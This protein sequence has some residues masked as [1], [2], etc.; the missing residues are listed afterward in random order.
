MSPMRLSGAARRSRRVAI[1]LSLFAIALPACKR[2]VTGREFG[3]GE[4]ENVRVDPPYVRAGVPM[5]IS[6]NLAGGVQRTVDYSIGGKTFECI[7]ERLAN[8]RLECLHAGVTRAEYMQGP[9]DVVVKTNNR[10]GNETSGSTNITI[11]FD[12]PEIS[13]LAVTPGIGSPGTMVR[14]DIIADEALSL[15][16]VVSR[17]G[18]VWETPIGL[19]STWETTHVVT[20]EDQ[21]SA[22][23]VIVRLVDL[24][25]NTSGDCGVDG[26]KIFS[27][28][29][30]APQVF[31]DKIEVLRD[32]PGLPATIS[33]QPGAFADDVGVTEV[34][35]TT[36]NESGA[37]HVVATLMPLSD[38]S[39]PLTAI[40]N[41]LTGRA[42]VQAID[43]AGQS[44]GPVLVKERWRLSVGMGQ[45]ADAAIR[46]ATR[47]T[48]APPRTPSLDNRTRELAVAIFNADTESAVVES[49]VGFKVAGTLPT[50]YRDTEFIATGY[51]KK[52]KAIVAFGGLT[53]NLIYRDETVVIRWNELSRS[54]EHVIYPADPGST[55]VARAGVNIAFDRTGC[56]I[57]FGGFD[58]LRYF[59]DVWQVC[60]DD[61]YRP[62]WT[63]IDT[64]RPAVDRFAPI[65]W[66]PVLDRFVT[67]FGP[68]EEGL[69]YPIQILDPGDRTGPWR[70]L[71]MTELPPDLNRNSR[72]QHAF[73]YDPRLPGYALGLG[74]T[75]YFGGDFWSF[76]DGQWFYSEV[77][78]DLWY[79]SGFGSAYDLARN[80]LVVW[81]DGRNR[82]GD[83]DD[84]VWL[85]ADDPR[86]GAQAWRRYDFSAPVIRGNPSMIY[87][88]DRET[89][90]IFGGR[91]A[92][93]TLFVPP[94]IEILVTAPSY[95]YLEADL[96]LDAVRPAGIAALALEIRAYASGDRDGVGPGSASGGGAIVTLWNHE[97]K[98]W[99]EVAVVDTPPAGPPISIPISITQNAARF[100]SADGVVPVSISPRYPATEEVAAKL[101]VDLVNGYLELSALPGAGAKIVAFDAAPELVSANESTQLSWIVLDAPDGVTVTD[102]AVT[103]YDGPLVEGT[104]TTAPTAT[105]TY[106]LTAKNAA[107]GN[108]TATRTVTVRP[109]VAPAVVLSFSA[110]EAA[111]PRGGTAHL[112]WS[113][114]RATEVR[115]SRG[116]TEI[117]RTTSPAAVANGAFEA[118]LPTGTVT[119]TV[120][121]IE[122]IGIA[123]TDLR[124]D[125]VR[126]ANE[127]IVTGPNGNLTFSEAIP[128][129]GEHDLFIV[130]M[131][132]PG[133]IEAEVFVPTAPQCM[134]GVDTLMRLLDSNLASLGSNDDGGVGSCSAFIRGD[135]SFILVEAG[136]Y[137]IEVSD[138]FDNNA[139]PAYTL[140]VTTSPTACG[141]SELEP[142]E[143]CDD[144]NTVSNDGCSATC[145]LEN[146]GVYSAPGDGRVVF[147]G[148]IPVAGVFRVY[149]IN[150]TMTTVVTM[151]TFVPNGNA[152]TNADTV[153][154]LYQAD[155][156]TQIAR[157]DDT[158]VNYCSSLLATLNPGTYYLTVHEL[159]DNAAIPAYELVINSV[160]GLPT[161]LEPND[162]YADATELGVVLS[163]SSSATIA[164]SVSP[165]ADEDWY[166]FTLTQSASVRVSTF[167]SPNNRRTCS[168]DNV[169]Y[170]YNANA[171]ELA[172][173]DDGIG[174]CGVLDGI[175]GTSP[176]DIVLSSLPAGTYLIRVKAYSSSRRIGA[177]FLLIEAR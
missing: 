164:A 155:Q 133:Y 78:G 139:I 158:D 129:A 31:A 170:F 62:R 87:D 34:R 90:V 38:G 40:E 75:F 24:A 15:P 131:N 44:S 36:T 7:P 43:V 143:G 94:D 50:S 61:E 134:T 49:S 65:L 142:N 157:N 47:Y 104:V 146:A 156:V 121:K 56:G 172:M 1:V 132:A 17:A 55:P 163:G 35:V 80:H 162:L 25:G 89:I 113:T 28:D 12:C 73:Y 166:T 27:V 138:Y 21:S 8:G 110:L 118:A 114:D 22:L 41:G 99:E 9:T 150:V 86:D 120:F 111:A 167:S 175:R 45:A 108:A 81:G 125:T 52:S 76:T 100:V 101:E 122:A 33:A 39:L 119:S 141:N 4:I 97:S 29:R 66:D 72:S 26:R 152:C 176:D 83:I 140:A 13:S 51:S 171:V 16:P 105:T 153:I 37:E 165:A 177:Y 63:L 128:V 19:D 159:G 148:T 109:R 57:M 173:N 42:R 18:R 174:N 3:G 6:F 2:P 14:V 68:S 147:P 95:P 130:Q 91:R 124:S 151:E 117:H 71:P 85:L 145:R 77:P 168:D 92:F 106:T 126:L 149:E 84:D 137:Y 102:G 20:D 23:D 123:G 10:L 116:N 69:D 60:L 127:R 11:D 169:L 93:D 58:D 82:L 54:Y 79:R 96:D 5:K 98:V 32:V 30:E 135:S 88:E 103:L 70:W 64:G 107:Q 136:T 67:S 161:E 59:G 74:S 46:T 48:P 53:D 160:T 112:R 154:E 115:I 144:G